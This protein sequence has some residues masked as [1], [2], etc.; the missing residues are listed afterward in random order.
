MKRVLSFTLTAA[1][2]LSLAVPVLAHR[3]TTAR[4]FGLQSS[5]REIMSQLLSAVPLPTEDWRQGV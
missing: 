2:A 1:L 4:T 3:L 5:A